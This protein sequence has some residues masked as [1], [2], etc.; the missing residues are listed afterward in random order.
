M[1]GMVSEY[2]AYDD[3]IQSEAQSIREGEFQD[4]NE[5]MA[6]LEDRIN[7]RDVAQPGTYD[8]MRGELM[9]ESQESGATIVPI[10]IPQQGGGYGGGGTTP[11]AGNSPKSVVGSSNPP[12]VARDAFTAGSPL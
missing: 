12:Y 7:A 5:I 11:T 1:A 2:D 3:V 10:V 9:A 4:V 8:A 6:E